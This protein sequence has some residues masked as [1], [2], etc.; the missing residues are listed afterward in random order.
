MGS[1]AW[2]VTCR[3]VITPGQAQLQAHR[4]PPICLFAKGAYWAAVKMYPEDRTMLLQAARIV[5]KS[6]E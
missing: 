1:A 6:K 4:A 2:R 3:E 5:E